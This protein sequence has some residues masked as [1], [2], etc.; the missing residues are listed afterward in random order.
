MR[1]PF[2]VITLA[3]PQPIPVDTPVITTLCTRYPP[4]NFV[5]ASNGHLGSRILAPHVLKT[6]Q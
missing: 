4:H 1:N 6:K 3:M 2:F 5:I